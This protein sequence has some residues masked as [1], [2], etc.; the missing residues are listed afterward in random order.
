M[1]SCLQ[2]SGGKDSLACLY[3][4]QDRWDE[5]I[6]AWVDTGAS[7][8]ETLQ[9]MEAVSRMV[10]DF[11]IVHATQS[12]DSRGFPVDMIPVRNTPVGRLLEPGAI[13]YQSRYDCC[14][15]ALWKP[16]VDACR[17]W[18]VTEVIRG[19]KRADKRRTPLQEGAVVEGVTFRF[20][21]ADWSDEEVLAYLEDRGVAL[22]GNY[23]TMGTGL[24]CWNC[25]AYLDE[26]QGKLEYMRQRHPEKH[27][28]VSSRLNTYREAVQRELPAILRS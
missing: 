7:F 3:L 2:F 28:I 26:N 10:P 24:D 25:T 11:R 21:I 15:A 13:A 5:I 20:P 6:V 12:I 17:E 4:L 8:P 27:A 22:P 1:K 23:A 16:M 19:T 9:Q 18:G 14:A